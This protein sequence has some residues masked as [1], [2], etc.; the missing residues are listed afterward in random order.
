M[1]KQGSVCLVCTPQIL[2]PLPSATV[3]FFPFSPQAGFCSSPLCGVFYSKHVTKTK[4]V[5]PK[6]LIPVQEIVAARTT[7]PT[8][9]QPTDSHT[10]NMLTPQG[11]R[12]ISGVRRYPKKCRLCLS[13]KLGHGKTKGLSKC[14]RRFCLVPQ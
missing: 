6:W 9:V 2:P 12:R 5:S 11:L 8:P 13:C 14:K 4:S 10:M 3:S 7:V 1:Q